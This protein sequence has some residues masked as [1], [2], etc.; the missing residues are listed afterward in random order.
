[1]HEK[2]R[3]SISVPAPL[4]AALIRRA[5]LEH[6]SLNNLILVMLTREVEQLRRK[7]TRKSK[8]DSDSQTILQFADID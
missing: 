5:E 7:D 8:Q 4:K 1:M 6:R 3:M 2:P